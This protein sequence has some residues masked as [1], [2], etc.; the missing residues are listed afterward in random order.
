LIGM[1]FAVDEFGNEALE[2]FEHE[3]VLQGGWFSARPQSH[4]HIAT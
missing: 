1:F 2:R 3:D 4:V